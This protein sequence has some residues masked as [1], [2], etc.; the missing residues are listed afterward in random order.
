M[1]EGEGR[2]ER[3]KKRERERGR[4]GGGRGR[5]REINGINLPCTKKES[6]EFILPLLDKYLYYTAHI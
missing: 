5:D 2:K 4:E 3:N 6:I 1:R